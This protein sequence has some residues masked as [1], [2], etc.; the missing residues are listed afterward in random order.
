[1]E[2]RRLIKR[3]ET[4]VSGSQGQLANGQWTPSPLDFSSPFSF[5]FFSSAI[6]HNHWRLELLRASFVYSNPKY[7]SSHALFLP[8]I[9][10]LILHS[11]QLSVGHYFQ[12]LSS[13]FFHL[14]IAQG[15]LIINIIDEWIAHAQTSSIVPKNSKLSEYTDCLLMSGGFN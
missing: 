13:L 15:S 6:R 5:Y 7:S 8:K 9:V 12:S 11:R 3:R 1:M 4:W 10:Y 14:I 2:R